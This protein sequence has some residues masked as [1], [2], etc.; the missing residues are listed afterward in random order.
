MNVQIETR[1]AMVAWIVWSLLA[2][3]GL[4]TV[5]DAI[6]PD[7]WTPFVIAAFAAAAI[8]WAWR[9]SRWAKR[10]REAIER[11]MAIFQMQVDDEDLR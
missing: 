9:E 8:P 10:Q 4:M 1:R 5:V 11:D 6:V 3:I 2:G 7:D